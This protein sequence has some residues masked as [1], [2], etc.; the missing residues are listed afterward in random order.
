MIMRRIHALLL[1]LL[2]ALPFGSAPPA[3]A[4]VSSTASTIQY[5]GNGSTRAFAFPYPYFQSSDLVVI[6]F[7]SS[8]G[9]AVSPAPVLNGGGTFD[10]TVTGIS[11]F[12]STGNNVL[13][14]ASATITFNSAPPGGDLVVIARSIAATQA[15]N[16]LD[17]AKFPASSVNAS[18]DRLTMLG[19]QLATAQGMS[20]QAPT[21]DPTGLGYI[22]PPVATR[23]SQYFCFDASGNV[24]ACAAGTGT[25]TISA[26]MV[27][28]VQSASLQSGIGVLWAGVPS[29]T[30]DLAP[31][32]A[33]DL[34]VSWDNS[35]AAAKSVRPV[36]LFGAAQGFALLNGDLTASVA[37][38]ALTVAIKT[39]AGNDPSAADPVYVVFRNATLTSGTKGVLKLT[40]A[41]SFTV[42]SGSTMGAANASP[43]RLWIVGFN[44][45]G[46]FRLGA[47]NCVSG[48]DIF[49]LRDDALQS[50]TAEGGAGAAD[51]AQ[52]IYTGTA[53]TTK[54]LRLLGYMEWSTGLTTAG[55]WASAPTKIQPFYV[56]INLPGTV[57]QTVS[58][59]TGAVA[60]GTTTMSNAD[61][62]PTSSQGDQYLTKAITPTATMNVLEVDAQ[63][64]GSISTAN[65]I[66]A[67]LYQDST[68]AALA[69]GVSAPTTSAAVTSVLMRHRLQ[70]ATVAATTFKVRAG[71]SAAGT[72]TLN[73]AG[74]AR[75]MGGVMFSRLTVSEIMD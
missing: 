68:A 24:S 45:A 32:A 67:A 71:D 52:V 73:G 38:S 51:S 63:V 43:F 18:L 25:T 30:E 11:A 69:A 14:F 31:D 55:T 29:V 62:I 28:V 23:A 26:A 13:E 17:N 35:A 61:T 20:V 2:L 50:S 64:F 65:T 22:L 21:S 41:T 47:V 34:L 56:G 12:S 3:G 53:V 49:P 6:L 54:P 75:L 44:D 8:T 74:G 42:S 10:Y 48:T 58:Q 72:F 1:V 9:A 70:A 46:T 19:Q 33:A 7:N 40:A 66:I 4:A 36:S 15:L 27:P 16:L 57:V 5:S 60:T 39:T 37:S 59:E